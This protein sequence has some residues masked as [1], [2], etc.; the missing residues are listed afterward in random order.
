MTRSIGVWF[1]TEGMSA[2]ES[3]AFAQRIE[4]LCYSRLWVGGTFGRDPFSHIAYLGAITEKLEFATGIANVYHRYPGVM[5]QAANTVAEEL[6]GRMIPALGVSSPQIVSKMPGIE[7]GKPLQF[8]R[9]Y[10]DSMDSSFYASIAPETPYPAVLAALGPNMLALAAER[11]AGAHTYNVNPER[12]RRA[13]ETLGPEAHL[14]VE[15]KVV[16]SM[17]ASKAREAAKKGLAFYRKAPE[18]RNCWMRLGSTAEEIDNAAPRFLDS[19]VA[20]GD[21]AALSN[22]VEEYFDAGASHKCIQPLDLDG[23]DAVPDWKAFEAL[24]PGSAE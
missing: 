16:L 22:R 13:R 7:Y 15:Q 12:A 4:T 6:G 3:A 9:Q 11:T 17:H 2:R 8:M 10:L 14:F 18:Y 19:T 1:P 23:R 5:K 24:A 20:W 21:E